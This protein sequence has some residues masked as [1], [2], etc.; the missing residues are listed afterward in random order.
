MLPLGLL[1]RLTGTKPDR[2]EAAD[3]A[4]RRVVEVAAMRAVMAT[5]ESLGYL[6]RDV[7][8]SKCGYDVESFIP[9]QLRTEATA[10]LRFL[11]VKGRAAGADTVTVTKNEILTALNTP[12]N[13][14]LALVEVDGSHTRTIYLKKPFRKAPEDSSCAVVYNL[15]ELRAGAEILLEREDDGGE[16]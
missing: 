3:A 7:S 6:P 12:E 15:A 5:E 8:A 14:I 9:A 10:S 2:T 16:A 13:F 1:R 11:E 4:A